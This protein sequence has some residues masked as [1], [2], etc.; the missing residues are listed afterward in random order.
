MIHPKDGK[1]KRNNSECL[2]VFV[3]LGCLKSIFW[4]TLF[5]K[6]DLLCM[7]IVSFMFT[8]SVLKLKLTH[9]INFAML[10]GQQIV[11][12]KCAI[13]CQ[14]YKSTVFNYNTSA[15]YCTNYEVVKIQS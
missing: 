4:D 11:R 7:I 3:E 1:W 10:L 2:T 9:N 6:G 14:N 13:C 15:I 12:I 8:V 5:V